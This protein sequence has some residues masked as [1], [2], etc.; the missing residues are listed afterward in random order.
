MKVDQAFYQFVLAAIAIV[1]MVVITVTGHAETSRELMLILNALV[2]A[3][4]WGGI[5]QRVN[6]VK[7]EQ[8]EKDA[9]D[10]TV[11]KLGKK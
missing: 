2:G 8:L 9:S 7:I 1:S 11:A 4:I 10:S 5:Q 3:G 6:N